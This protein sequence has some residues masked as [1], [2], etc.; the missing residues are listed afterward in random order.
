[1]NISVRHEGAALRLG[2]GQSV[3]VRPVGPAD[4]ESIQV[5]VRRLSDAS[6]RLRFFAPI[7]ELAPAMLARLT[8]SAGQPGLVLL[9]QAHDGEAWS[10]VALAQYAPGE[11]DTCDL[12]LVVADAWQ[13]LGLGRAL[14]G[15]LTRSARNEGYARAVVDVLWGNEAMIALASACEFAAARSP[16]GSTVVRL[17]RELQDAP[18]ADRAWIPAGRAPWAA[19]AAAFAA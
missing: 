16:L 18:S 7:R 8:A 14:M 5:F 3:H 2:N 9:A 13:G 1:M 6:R 12:A 11:D 10:T 17:V 19:P 15:L 4:A